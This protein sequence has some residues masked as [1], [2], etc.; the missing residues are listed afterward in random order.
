[1]VRDDHVVG[2]MEEQRT[3][4]LR[5]MEVGAVLE[6]TQVPAPG[7]VDASKPMARVR[8]AAGATLNMGN[9]ESLRYDV[10]VEVPCKPARESIDMAYDYARKL[11]DEKLQA[12]IDAARKGAEE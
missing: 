6:S 2:I 8:F 5:K 10:A 3:T 9:F 1:M 12:E 4:K 7:P 11:V